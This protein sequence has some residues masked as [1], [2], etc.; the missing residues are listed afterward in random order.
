MFVVVFD[1]AYVVFDLVFVLAT[2]LV[3]DIAAILAY[4]KEK[5]RRERARKR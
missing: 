2:V 1:L 5:G 4:C 3:V